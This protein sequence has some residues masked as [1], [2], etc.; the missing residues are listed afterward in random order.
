MPSGALASATVPLER[1]SQPF[2]GQDMAISEAHD[3]KNDTW[4]LQISLCIFCEVVGV[5]EL[6]TITL[7]PYWSNPRLQ[8][9]RDLHWSIVGM[10]QISF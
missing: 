4:I 10:V 2:P 6:T 3:S 9:G 7:F 5:A 1:A 8:D